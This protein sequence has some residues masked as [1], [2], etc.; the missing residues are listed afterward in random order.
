MAWAKPQRPEGL[1]QATY[2]RL[3]EQL[4]VR[5]I[6]VSVNVPV[7]P[8]RLRFATQVINSESCLAA[9]L[10]SYAKRCATL[11]DLVPTTTYRIAQASSTATLLKLASSRLMNV[12][13]RIANVARTATGGIT[14]ST[15][16]RHAM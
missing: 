1:D 3:P 4:E 9:T 14:P 6:E 10:V 12:F 13:D 15:A 7:R 8:H 11:P 2:D 5:E 16:D